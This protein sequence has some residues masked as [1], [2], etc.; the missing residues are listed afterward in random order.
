MNNSAGFLASVN[1]G[2]F[3]L[4]IILKVQNVGLHNPFSKVVNLAMDWHLLPMN[5]YPNLILYHFHIIYWFLSGS[6]G[7]LDFIYSA[8]IF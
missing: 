4:K 2:P 1:I 3:R 7:Y 5:S 6:P 8:P